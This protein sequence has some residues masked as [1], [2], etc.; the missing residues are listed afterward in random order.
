MR[1]KEIIVQNFRP[2]YGRQ[3][4]DLR[5]EKRKPLILIEALNDVGKTSLFK[6][7]QFCLY[8]SKATGQKTFQHINRT[9]CAAGDGTMLVKLSFDHDEKFYEIIRS[10]EFKKEIYGSP[11]EFYEKD[12]DVIEN[13]KSV[14]LK[15]S[16]EQNE[17]IEAMLPEEASQ[18]FLFDGEEIKKYTEHPPGDNVRNAIEM[19]LGIKELRNA[20]D[21][22][23]I[24]ISDVKH[25]LDALL[26][27]QT[28]NN[29]E[30]VDVEELGKE[31]EGLRKDIGDLEE[32]KKQAE[33]N[34][35]SFDE[36]LKRNKAIQDKIEQRKKEEDN[37][38]SILEQI[39]TNED[40]MRDFN[41]HLAVI[42]ITP[43]LQELSKEARTTTEDWKRHALAVLIQSDRCICDRPIDESIRRKFERLLERNGGKSVRNYLG[44][45]AN[46]LLLLAEPA[47]C[48]KE[49]SYI[50]MNH[51]T[52]RSNL[53]ISQQAIDQLTQEIGREKIPADV[54]GT[55]DLRNRAASD[56]ETYQTEISKKKAL[57]ELKNAEHKR[58]QEKLAAQSTDKDVQNKSYCKA[59]AE[60]CGDGIQEVINNIVEKSKTGVA[61]LAS[62]VFLKLTN[63]PQLYLG[64]EITDEYELKIKTIGGVVRPVW[65]QMPSSG[66]SQIIATSF[67]AALN[68]YSAKEAPIVI[69]TPIGRLDPIHKSNL[70]K[71][72]PDLSSQV[73][74]LYQ[75]NELTPEDIAP[76]SK[77][78]SSEWQFDR[79][80]NNPDATIITRM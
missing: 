36:T 58:R 32:W 16:R 51:N 65:D 64:I 45:Q 42:L 5:T 69:D 54:K 56:L 4:I 41:Q 18:F 48:E 59:S 20:R 12:V 60:E 47:A 35:K 14:P 67:I 8:G 3:V 53:T 21:D 80:P 29:K 77:Y 79:D 23:E 6:A 10:V 13:G 15:T 27:K 26:V 73:V 2:F 76:I 34:I 7:I 62:E 49:L 33:E 17:F 68:R 38:N 70:I 1:V 39:K 30:A 71:Y 40:Q 22:L 9:A 52:F 46:N 63:A 25:E 37:R 50:L 31:V 78:I 75:P 19:V 66:Q 28:S 55:S 57:L 74:I 24:V 61:T 72:F 44:D 11:I 43:L